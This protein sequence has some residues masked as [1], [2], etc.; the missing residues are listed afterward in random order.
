MGGEIMTNRFDELIKAAETAYNTRDILQW[1]GNF[2]NPE[3]TQFCYVGAALYEKLGTL[4]GRWWWSD[5]TVMEMFN[6]EY[7][8]VNV[9]FDMNDDEKLHWTEISERLRA[10]K[11]VE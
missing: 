10:M 1:Q 9:I 8:D 3:C 11:D 5:R 6:L 7:D 2:S 4:N